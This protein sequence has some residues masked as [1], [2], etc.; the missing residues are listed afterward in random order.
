MSAQAGHG[1]VVPVRVAI[2][3]ES[4]LPDVNGVAN[5]VARI[6]EQAALAGDDVLV[7]APGPSPMLAYHGAEVIRVPGIRLASLSGLRLGWTTPQQIER[8][9]GEF[10]PDVVHLASP[11]V[12][13][14]AGL[15]AARALALPV[16]A[17]YQTDVAG[18]AAYYGFDALAG[19]GATW[20]GRLH[21]KADL[22][23]AP[24]SAAAA[25]LR[26]YGVENVAVWGRGIDIDRFNPVKADPDLRAQWTAGGRVAVGFVGRLAPEKQAARLLGLD[27]D[28]R[29][30]LVFIGDGP[31]RS[32]IERR[33]PGAHFTG[34]LTGEDLPRAMAALDVLVH[35]GENETFC[36]VVQEGHASGLPVVAPA[37]GGPLDLI[38]PGVTGELYRPGDTGHLHSLVLDLV[39]DASARARMGQAGRRAVLGRTW[40]ALYQALTGHYERAIARRARVREG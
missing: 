28:P 17:L 12:L 31:A 14:A 34:M 5:S 23:L 18:F 21:R 2:V 10:R 40:P 19:V 25:V 7:I 30:Q 38:T 4:F 29:V 11:F 3:A 37:V 9:L 35:T 32:A 26:S 27:A 36:Q 24:S 8:F 39:G 6:C 16:V 13:G 22:N 33:A 15:R 1:E 20:T